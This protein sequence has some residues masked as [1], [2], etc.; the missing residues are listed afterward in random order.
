MPQWQRAMTIPGFSAVS[1]H[2]LSYLRRIKTDLRNLIL[3]NSQDTLVY[4]FTML[5][6]QE[7]T[8]QNESQILIPRE[9]S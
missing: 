8:R 4:F 7:K 1:I 5:K 6:K 3:K 2:K 9:E